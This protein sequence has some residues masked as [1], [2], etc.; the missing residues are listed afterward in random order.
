MQHS[1]THITFYHADILLSLGGIMLPSVEFPMIILFYSYLTSL[2][3]P[4]YGG[5][6][7]LL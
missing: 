4:Y 6:T 5:L 1:N 7:M 2:K 3:S